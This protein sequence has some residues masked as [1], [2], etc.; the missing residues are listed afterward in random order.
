MICAPSESK[1]VVFGAFS[2]F[3]E[4]YL[5]LIIQSKLKPLLKMTKFAFSLFSKAVVSIYKVL[6]MLLKHSF[7]LAF[8]DNFYVCLE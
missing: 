5:Y 4:T 1:T 8:F 7:I 2:C 6:F 3:L